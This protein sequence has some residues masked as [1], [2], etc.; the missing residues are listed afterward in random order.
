MIAT[1][2][3]RE[4]ALIY[5][6]PRSL[7]WIWRPIPEPPPGWVRLRL[8]ACGICGS[9]VHGYTGESGRRVPPLVMGHEAV[10]EVV[11]IGEG[12][13]AIWMGERCAL[14]PILY[15]G[16]CGWCQAGLMQHCEQRAFLGGT[17]DGAM[18]ES[19]LAPVESLHALPGTLDSASATLVEPLAVA[20]RAAARAGDLRDRHVLVCGA[21]AIG[22]LV[23]MAC[24]QAGAGKIAITDIDPFH[25]RMAASLGFEEV[26]DP[27]GLGLEESPLGSVRCD[28]AFDAVG[29]TPTFNA[30]MRSLRK[31]G[32]L[33]AVAGWTKV[34][35]PVNPLVAGELEFRG[36][37]NY[38][39]EE[40]RMALAWLADRPERFSSC[41]T[42]RRPLHDGADVFSALSGKT[43]S[44]IR[45][46][47]EPSL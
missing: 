16:G 5:T 14:Q 36:T 10:G 41:I 37:F 8:L 25:R 28:V 13:S 15:C 20:L 29:I 2:A 22:L 38:S 34:N 17:R 9:D 11:A 39:A 44:A 30:A 47:L 21:G 42:H 27:T 3:Q 19:F 46:V 7:E 32:L 35:F 31:G 26:I 33:V 43:L 40:F 6:G 12:V 45:V 1:D 18:A 23:A 24:Q 4:Q